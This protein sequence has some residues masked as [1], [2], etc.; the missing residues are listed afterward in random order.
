[1]M[2]LYLLAKVVIFGVIRKP[3][4]NL[5]ALAETKGPGSGMMTQIVGFEI[6]SDQ[7]FFILRE[8]LIPCPQASGMREV[9]NPGDPVNPV[10]NFFKIF[11]RFFIYA[12]C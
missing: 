1:M 4:N 5:L 7:H 8:Q 9:N 2:N 6:D 11:R 10:K 3:Y 12:T